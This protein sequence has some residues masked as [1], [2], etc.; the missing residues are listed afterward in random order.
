MFVVTALY[1]I[2]V[3]N[4]TSVYEVVLWSGR[5]TGGFSSGYSGFRPQKR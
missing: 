2:F 3:P 5:R 1:G 4:W